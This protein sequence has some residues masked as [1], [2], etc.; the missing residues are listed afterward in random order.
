MKELETKGDLFL[1]KFK[2][3]EDSSKGVH[4]VENRHE[5]E[6][7][8]IPHSLIK[9]SEIDFKCK[10]SGE[11]AD[12]YCY[13]VNCNKNFCQACLNEHNAENQGHEIIYFSDEIEKF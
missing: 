3:L 10:C 5:E 8:E 2:K 11:Y 1:E 9:Y 4:K 6:D 7:D 13:C 12:Y